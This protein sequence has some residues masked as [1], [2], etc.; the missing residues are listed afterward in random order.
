VVGSIETSDA[1]KPEAWRRFD[2]GELFGHIAYASLVT[3]K[4]T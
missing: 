4:P 2:A 1:L 3:Q